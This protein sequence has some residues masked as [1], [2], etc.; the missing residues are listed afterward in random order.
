MTAS[1]AHDGHAKGTEVKGTNAY[2]PSKLWS[3]LLEK[4][5]HP[6]DL[7]GRA[8]A[9]T[10]RIPFDPQRSLERKVLG[11]DHGAQDAGDG[12]RWLRGQL[13]GELDGSAP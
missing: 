3:S 6:F 9:A 2:L 8:A 7:V 13:L 10:D 1:T 11:T 12:D 4:R 5:L